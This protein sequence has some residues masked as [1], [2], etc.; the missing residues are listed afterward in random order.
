MNTQPTLS[1]LQ[2]HKIL[3]EKK[4]NKVISV[5]GLIYLLFVV[6]TNLQKHVALAALPAK[7]ASHGIG[8]STVAKDYEDANIL[9]F[10]PP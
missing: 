2:T 9:S 5:I 8:T 7:E 6:G 3:Q 10:E 1:Y 4:G